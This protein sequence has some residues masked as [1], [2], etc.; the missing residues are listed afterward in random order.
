MLTANS[1][2]DVTVFCSKKDLLYQ[3][4]QCFNNV[5]A[6]NHFQTSTNGLH[7]DTP[8]FDGFA[9]LKNKKSSSRSTHKKRET[10]AFS[11]SLVFPFFFCLAILTLGKDVS[12]FQETIKCT[13]LVEYPKG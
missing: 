9:L 5:L 1:P 13:L 7:K 12:E 11:Q 3:Q 10:H 2:K 6:P 8:F 4:L